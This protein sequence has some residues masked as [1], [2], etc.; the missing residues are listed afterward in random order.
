MIVHDDLEICKWKWPRLNLKI[1]FWN[2]PAGTDG[3]H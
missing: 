3:N 1:L 2:F